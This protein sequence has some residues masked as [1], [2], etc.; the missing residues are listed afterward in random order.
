M[1]T[2]KSLESNLYIHSYECVG[3]MSFG[4]IKNQQCKFLLNQMLNGRLEVLIRLKMRTEAEGMVTRGCDFDLSGTSNNLKVTVQQPVCYSKNLDLESQ[5]IILECRAER[6]KIEAAAPAN[7]SIT[8]I[9]C[10]CTN[11]PVNIREGFKRLQL[12]FCNLELDLFPCTLPKGARKHSDSFAHALVRANLVIRSIHGPLNLD[13]AKKAVWQLELL[14]SLAQ[15]SWVFVVSQRFRDKDGHLLVS[16]FSEPA[17]T[18]APSR[19]LIPTHSLQDFIVSAYPKFSNESFREQFNLSAVVDHY[20]TANSI[21]SIW[22]ASVGVLIAIETL[23]S[24]WKRLNKTITPW[25]VKSY[26][27]P[28]QLNVSREMLNEILNIVEHHNPIFKSIPDHDRNKLLEQIENK[29]RYRSWSPFEQQ[30][31]VMLKSLNVDFDESELKDFIKFR[32]SIVHL[33][34][35]VDTVDPAEKQELQINQNTIRSIYGKTLLEK[36]LLAILEYKGK[37]DLAEDITEIVFKNDQ[38]GS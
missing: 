14:L 30:L 6:A 27:D 13:L 35:P 3:H 4:K 19:A 24:A 15:R 8:E 29:I 25:Q 38:V 21:R 22:P 11:L 18:Y 7:N 36:M 26:I 9:V 34:S 20:V 5:E 33:G 17:F 16:E 2:A 23:N 32:D 1:V 37:S 31:R 28:K 12:H 10:E